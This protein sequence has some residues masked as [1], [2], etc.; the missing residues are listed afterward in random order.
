MKLHLVESFADC[1]TEKTKETKL[2]CFS[3]HLGH[4][5]SFLQASV[6]TFA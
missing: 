1:F 3:E 6:Y 4:S 5:S 2:A